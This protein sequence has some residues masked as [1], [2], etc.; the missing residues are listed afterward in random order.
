MPTDHALT[1]EYPRVILL[2]RER[3]VVGSRQWSGSGA[4]IENA[5]ENLR[6]QFDTHGADMEAL[7][8][9]IEPVQESSAPAPD[10]S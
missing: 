4:T 1:N 8:A 10:S 2:V 3:P 6:N 9:L 7:S 5:V